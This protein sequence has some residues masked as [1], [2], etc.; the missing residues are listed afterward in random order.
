[1]RILYLHN[2]GEPEWDSHCVVLHRLFPDV[3]I[4]TTPNTYTEKP[5]LDMIF[6]Y[7]CFQDIDYIVGDGFGGFLAYIAGIANDTKTILINPYIPMADYLAG[8]PYI[9]ENRDTFNSLWENNKGQNKY[10]SVILDAKTQVPDLKKTFDTL[11][12][13]ADT[14]IYCTKDTLVYSK[15]YETWMVAHIT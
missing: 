4:I 13:I 7:E 12:D 5:I 3:E 6:D 14:Y 1:M 10:C 9:E 8:V 15:E 2:F 11:K